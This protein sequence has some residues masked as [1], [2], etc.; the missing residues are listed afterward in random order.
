[1][2]KSKADALL[3]AAS[4]GKTAKIRDLLAAGAP[5]EA[6]DVNRM[7]P[8]PQGPRGRTTVSR[9]RT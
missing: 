6:T 1:M 3:S 9:P 5:L 4:A 2:D 8:V 7:T